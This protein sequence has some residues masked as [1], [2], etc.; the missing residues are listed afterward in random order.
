VNLWQLE[1]SLDRD[2]AWRKRELSAVKLAVVG[3]TGL[4]EQTLLRAAIALLYA[5]WEGFVKSAGQSY[6]EFV[7][8]QGASYQRL[9]PVFRSLALRALVN[10]AAND[11]GP[12]GRTDLCLFLEYNMDDEA[13][14]PVDGVVDT[15]HNL[16]WRRFETI[17]MALDL[18]LGSLATKGPLIDEK[19]VRPRNGIAHGQGVAIDGDDYAALH[20]DVIGLLDTVRDRVEIS[21]RTARY[22]A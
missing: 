20:T 3:A 13:D 12:I 11:A 18:P 10:R 22:L 16:W 1:N 5:H 8:N 7:A 17:M 15:G 19:L 4:A 6:L 21:A 14:V 2:L 9:S